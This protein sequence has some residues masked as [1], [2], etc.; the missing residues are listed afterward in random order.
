[1]GECSETS[2]DAIGGSD[3]DW[4]I[5]GRPH[6]QTRAKALIKSGV[7]MM[8]QSSFRVPGRRNASRSMSQS[9]KKQ[10]LCDSPYEDRMALALQNSPIEEQRSVTRFLTAEGRESVG[11]DQRPGQANT[12]ITSDLIDKVNDLVRSDRRVTLR[13]LALKVDVSYGSV[14]TIVHDRLR[15][16]KVCATWVPKQLTD[17]QKELRMGLALQHLFRY[18]E[19][20]AFMKRIVTGDETWCHHYEPETKRDSMQWKHASSPPPKKFRAV[21]SAGKVLFTVFFDVQDPLLVEFL[22]HRKTLTP[23]CTSHTNGTGQVQMGDVGPSALQSGYVALR[24]PCVWSTE[25]TPE[26][27]ALQLGRRTQGHSER[28]GLV[29]ATGILGTKGILRLVHQFCSGLWKVKNAP[30]A[31]NKIC[32]VSGE[33]AIVESCYSPSPFTAT[34]SFRT[35]FKGSIFETPKPPFKLLPHKGIPKRLA[36]NCKEAALQWMFSD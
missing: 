21:M 17:L 16:R 19:D 32:A 5:R 11:D 18:Q 26:R 22:E 9:P 27:E 8:R 30:Q 12:V 29:T 24:F 36:G 33:V 31:T 1:M 2:P 4:I 20:P 25:E 34:D 14:W 15:F 13:M 6:A 7:Q 3:W 28:L 10:R 23:M 35:F